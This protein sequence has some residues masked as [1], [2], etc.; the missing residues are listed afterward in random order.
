MHLLVDV[1]LIKLFNSV[2]HSAWQRGFVF[3]ELGL[4]NPTG[5]DDSKLAGCAKGSLFDDESAENRGTPT[6][7]IFDELKHADVYSESYALTRYGAFWMDY[8]FT[9]N[10]VA[11]GN[12]VKR[13]Q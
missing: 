6:I 10:E 11:E 3:F 7:Y 2:L 12:Y 9:A 1:K 5:L 13:Y 8:M 4:E